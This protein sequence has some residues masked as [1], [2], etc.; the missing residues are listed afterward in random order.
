M[1]GNALTCTN[2]AVKTCKP[3][4]KPGSGDKA[5]TCLRDTVCKDGEYD[6]LSGPWK[7]VN[8]KCERDLV[9]SDSKFDDGTNDTCQSCKQHFGDNAVAECTKDEVLSCVTGFSLDKTSAAQSCKCQDYQY[10]TVSPTDFGANV[11]PKCLSCELFDDPKATRCTAADGSTQ[12]MTGY[13][14]IDSTVIGGDRCGCPTGQFDNNNACQECGTDSRKNAI[15][16]TKTTVT[17]CK[18]GWDAVGNEC[19]RSF[20]CTDGQYDD[21]VAKECQVCPGDNVETCNSA[22]MAV[23]CKTS[24]VLDA[25]NDN[26]CTCKAGTYLGTQDGR[27]DTPYCRQ[28]SEFDSRASECRLD[29]GVTKCSGS[30][31][32]PV[33]APTDGALAGKKVCGCTDPTNFDDGLECKACSTA[34]KH[35]AKCT[36]TT[37]LACDPDWKPATGGKSC[38]RSLV[39]TTDGEYDDHISS[40]CVKCS[41]D[42][43]SGVAKCSFE[44]GIISCGSTLT[45]SGTK[46]DKDQKCSC[47]SNEYAKDDGSCVACTTVDAKALRCEDASTTAL[48]ITQNAS[49]AYLRTCSPNQF[50]SNGQCRSCP[51]NAVCDG[52]SFKCNAPN[53]AKAQES[54]TCIAVAS[55]CP[56]NRYYDLT[57]LQCQDCPQDRTCKDGK[58]LPNCPAT[59]EPQENN[60]CGC[61]APKWV[62]TRDG[63][64]V[65]VDPLP[66]GLYHG[67][68]YVTTSTGS[69]TLAFIQEKDVKVSST[70]YQIVLD[71][72]L[73]SP[74]FSASQPPSADSTALGL[75]LLYLQ[76]SFAGSETVVLRSNSAT[77]KIRWIAAPPDYVINYTWMW[78]LSKCP[79]NKADA[80]TASSGNVDLLPNCI[81]TYFTDKGCFTD[82][83]L[84]TRCA[85][86]PNPIAPCPSTRFTWKDIRDDHIPV[87][88]LQPNAVATFIRSGIRTVGARPES[89]A[90]AVEQLT[91]TVLTSLQLADDGISQFGISRVILTLYRKANVEA[92]ATQF[93]ERAV[94]TGGVNMTTQAP[95]HS[96]T[97]TSSTVANDVDGGSVRSTAERKHYSQ[98][99]DG[100][101]RLDKRQQID[102]HDDADYPNLTTVTKLLLTLTMTMAMMLN[103]PRRDSDTQR[104]IIQVQG[105]TLAL[106]R[107]GTDLDLLVVN[108]QWLTSAY[109]LAFGCVL[110]LFGRIADIYG[111]RLAFLCSMAWFYAWSLA[112]GWSPNEVAIDIF[113]AMQGVGMGAAIPSALGIL[114]TSFAPGHTKSWAFACFSA[115]APLGGSLGSVL[116]GLL[117]QFATWRAFFWCSAGL[118]F[119]IGLLAFVTVPKNGPRDNGLTVDWIGAILV[120]SGL[121]LLTFALADGPGQPKGFKTPY[122]PVFLILGVGLCIAFWFWERHLEFHTTRQPLMHTS[123]W[124]KERFALVQLIAALGWCSF[125]SFMFLASL[126]FQDLIKLSPALAAVRFL[127]APVTGIFLNAIV[128]LVAA[129]VPANYLISIGCLGTGLASMLFALQKQTD[130]YWQWQFPAMIL[131]VVGADLIYCCGV[132]YVSKIAGSKHQALAGGLFNCST[133]IGTSIGLAINTII[134][135][136]VT[137]HWLHR[138]QGQHV[139][140]LATEKGLQAAFW[141]CAGF[142]WLGLVISVV[143]LNK[144]GCV[145]EKKSKKQIE[146]VDDD[147]EKQIGDLEPVVQQ[148][149]TPE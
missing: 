90:T 51:A 79:A 110:L 24:F 36:K 50:L 97:A 47:K 5:N 120:T 142:A 104:Q 10:R 108:Y 127:P 134:Q 7:A 32:Q 121:T 9:C 55:T 145:G 37:V 17:K 98:V 6:D 42:F 128:G 19:R 148:A 93:D 75:N 144:I 11:V 80:Y 129:I 35:A 95:S 89:I 39:C 138:S 53:F 112:A 21:G 116:G 20:T 4:W 31:L 131:S 25:D 12:C 16:C 146:F 78:K 64:N 87:R 103:A 102:D 141:G 43:G 74:Q 40:T 2:T 18:L 81:Q 84:S 70:Q 99:P 23:T 101:S 130:P 54:N 71:Y 48:T 30:A 96:S 85:F 58:L 76:T 111:H 3:L 44:R 52:N 119:L 61:T 86:Q 69:N 92:E 143:C 91:G 49:H 118:G 63:A 41:K 29:L 57:S 94:A 126:Y 45:L 22:G 46:A 59:M 15:E 117:T 122:I 115:G 56:G 8:G 105:V 109:A 65:C 14:V 38:V 83:S 60:E 82:L 124:F 73:N 132:L 34:F 33:D 137:S 100:Q 149:K 135:S 28:C 1:D 133:Q 62:Y 114:G 66:I 72:V 139:L 140:E 27:P 136:K 107:I 68:N 125:A 123:L 88:K 113:R 77:S 13:Q 26:K 106:Q 67:Y 147:K